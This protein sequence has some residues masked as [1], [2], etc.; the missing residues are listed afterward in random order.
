M[1]SPY[2]RETKSGTEET[3]E[4]LKRTTV[5]ASRIDT[6]NDATKV[7]TD[8]VE[9]LNQEE[10]RLRNKHKIKTTEL[11]VDNFVFNQIETTQKILCGDLDEKV[12][13]LR[14]LKNYINDE[15]GYVNP[16]KLSKEQLL[17]LTA[18]E[19][20]RQQDRI[21]EYSQSKVVSLDLSDQGETPELWQNKDYPIHK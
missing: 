11:A 12:S 10:Q 16:P 8:F 19:V 21:D 17:W 9:Q 2:S 15:F 7:D 13:A 3:I 18:R 5:W 1:S 14:Q 4:A 20:Q 6:K